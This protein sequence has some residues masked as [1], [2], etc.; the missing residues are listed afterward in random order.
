[1]INWKGELKNDNVEKSS[2]REFKIY[3][4]GLN[5]P[6]IAQL[7][8]TD[9]LTNVYILMLDNPIESHELEFVIKKQVKPNKSPGLDGLSPGLFKWLFTQWITILAFLLLPK[10]LVINEYDFKK[11]GRLDCSNV[12]G[13]SIMNAISKIYD[14]VLYNRLVKG[15]LPDREQAGAQ[16]KR[17]CIEHILTLRLLINYCIV[18]KNFL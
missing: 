3:L 17:I 14:Y 11:R 4:D 6:G 5:P 8:E 9:Y 16:Y 1:L 18:K 7:N 12:R 13:I 10:Y 15:V 2:D